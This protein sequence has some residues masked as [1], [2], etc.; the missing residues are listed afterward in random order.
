[1]GCTLFAAVSGSSTATTATVGKITIAEL[2]QR[3]YDTNLSIGSL[4]GAGSL[5]LLI[6][7]SIVMI[8]YGILAAQS[9]R[10]LFIAGV[11]PGLMIAAFYSIFIAIRCWLDRRLSPELDHSFRLRDV[12]GGLI[13]LLPVV[14]LI[15]LV[16]GSI[17]TGIATP[18]E[19]AAVGLAGTIVMVV[20]LGQF[21]WSMFM[22]AL[23]SAVVTS[24]MVCSIVVG[25]ALLSTSMGYL[26]VPQ[27]IAKAIGTLKL[28]PIELIL[29]I[30]AFY[31][32]LGLFLDGISILVMSLPITLPLVLAAGFDP[33]WFGIFLV[34]MI[35]LGQVTPPIGFNLFVLQGL[36]GHSIGR[37]A[38][39]ALPFFFLMLGAVVVITAFPEIVLCL[40]DLL[41]PVR[42]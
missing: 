40:P 17:Y 35:E 25:A 41:R 23:L 18:S 26:H 16:L 1:M 14:G 34:I 13:D 27:E 39:A 36:T 32:V 3:G 10:D 5:G 24:T 9:V 28:S 29:L 15:L 21:S 2:R 37:V 33:I 6:P 20:L 42:P 30:G 31:I 4:A 12:L 7:P 22:E 38:Y 8:V 11:L 19:A